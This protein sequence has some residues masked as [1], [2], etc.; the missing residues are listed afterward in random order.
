MPIMDGLEATRRLTKMMDNNEIQRIPII[1]LT[2]FTSGKDY[3]QCI[4][5]GMLHVLQKPL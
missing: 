3:E 1:G 5:A 4:S 2:A